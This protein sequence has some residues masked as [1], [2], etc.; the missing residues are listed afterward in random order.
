MPASTP[1]GPGGAGNRQRKN[2]ILL[3]TDQQRADSLGC[4]GNSC[5]RT[6]NLDRLAAGGTLFTRHI[7]ANPI[8]CPSRA[9]LLTG[10]YPPGHNV[11]CNGVPLNRLEYATIDRR[12][13]QQGPQS[14]GGFH[15]EP[16]TLADMFAGAGYDTASFGKLHLTPYLGPTSY[17]HHENE[18]LWLQG[19]FT[20]WHGP[21]YGFRYVDMI[22][23]HGEQ[24]CRAGHYADWLQREHPEAY[25]RVAEG[26]PERPQASVGD[27]Y[28]ST[29]PFELHHSHWLADRLCAYLSR[30]RPMDRPFCAF[31]GFPDPHHP[32][33]PCEEI[34]A[35]FKDAPVREPTDPEGA[36]VRHSPF[37][38]L[39]QQNARN[40]DPEA[41]RTIRRYTHAMEHQ[42][43]LAV[44]QILDT[45][46]EL[47]L[48]DDTIVVFTSDHGDFL[49]DHGY[50]RKGFAA[51]DALLRVPLV[52]R[53]PGGGLPPRVDTPA[54]NC[55]VMPTLAALTGVTPP[56]GLHGANLVE[57][58]NGSQPHTALAF[59]SNGA[60]DSMNLT[61]YDAAHRLTW[62]PARDF[63]ELFDH[64]ADPGE[65]ANIANDPDQAQTIERL[66]NVLARG[67]ADCY[68]PILNRLCAW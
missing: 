1:A 16:T 57:V 53:A 5:A 30:E 11:W 62:Y 48:A 24:P 64:A 34:V 45:L 23:G 67:L 68:N 47:G 33:T 51:S 38:A 54:G 42:I 58:A 12:C 22:I 18:E 35:H 6:P 44:G 14:G 9:S 40:L 4:M 39:S 46:D 60:P 66:R 3:H 56:P 15:P 17:G 49:G 50:L 20:D 8:C 55:D 10:L 32:F 21:Y 26:K 59:S 41:I 29:L 37:E 43:D 2:V 52:M 28:A 27:L 63:T 13:E 25:R 61:V 19:A 31:V 7:S 36:G 65:T